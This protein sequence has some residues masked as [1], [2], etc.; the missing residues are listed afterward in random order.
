MSYSIDVITST[1]SEGGGGDYLSGFNSRRVWFAFH[2]ALE[3]LVKGTTRS[4]IVRRIS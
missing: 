3:K 1:N 4:F 2:I